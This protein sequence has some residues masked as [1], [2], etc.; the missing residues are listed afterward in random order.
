M[1]K[2]ALRSCGLL[3]RLIEK[4]DNQGYY[5]SC[6]AL[7]WPIWLRETQEQL[8]DYQA[9]N[10]KREISTAEAEQWLQSLQYQTVVIAPKPE[11][12][13]TR[14]GESYEFIFEDHNR[15][16][17]LSWSNEIPDGWQVIWSVS[18]RLLEIARSSPTVT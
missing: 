5:L 4:D 8:E 16:M 10:W 1:V 15:K 3:V 9:E 11:D 13:Q 18:E 2:P 6:W 7:P 14:D 17:Q 12:F